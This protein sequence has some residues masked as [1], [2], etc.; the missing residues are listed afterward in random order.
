MLLLAS[1]AAWAAEPSAPA[2]S[3]E[4]AFDKAASYAGAISAWRQHP[5]VWLN[6]CNNV[7]EEGSPERRQV[8]EAW[9]SANNDELARADDLVQ[10]A[11]ERAMPKTGGVDA[12]KAFNAAVLV[13]LSRAVH[14]MDAAE[15][16]EMCAHYADLAFFHESP[17]EWRNRAYQYL[18]EWVSAKRAPDGPV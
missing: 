15:K 12:G 10:R 6:E 17:E 1:I 9:L 13:E 5:I 3:E 8:Y 14:S 16:A 2:P 11:A 7:D 4:E 18:E